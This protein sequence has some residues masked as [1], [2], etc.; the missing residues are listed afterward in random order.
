MKLSETEKDWLPDNEVGDSSY[1]TVND[2]EGTSFYLAIRKSYGL[3]ERI[4]GKD[5]DTA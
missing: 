5:F 1:C 3:R 2:N 4:Q